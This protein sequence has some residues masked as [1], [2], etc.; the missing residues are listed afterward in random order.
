MLGRRSKLATP[1]VITL[2][3]LAALAALV[4][5]EASRSGG[6]TRPSRA[7][8]PL[9]QADFSPSLDP[10]TRLSGTAPNFTL[11]DQFGK[12]VSLHSFRGKVVLLAFNDSE[13]TTICPLTTTAMTDARRMLGPAGSQVA[14]LGVDAN[15]Q[16]TFIKDV[17]D[18]SEVHGMTHLWHFTTGPLPQLK[19]VWKAY[20]IESAIVGGQVD[21][22]PALYAISPGG[23][24]ARLYL[25]QMSYAS[26]TQQAQVLA[27]EASSLLPGHPGVDSHLSYTPVKS[28]KP[29]RSTAMPPRPVC[30]GWSQSMRRASSPPPLP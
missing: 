7:I 25:T 11:T 18:Y 4:V 9:R 5:I 15:P 20:H 27:T 30:R 17:R 13:C 28:I 22:T 26:V 8:S 21:H 1:V 2:L 12:P 19:R 29:K 14:L 6:G 10:G 16:A 24:L 23:K 3:A